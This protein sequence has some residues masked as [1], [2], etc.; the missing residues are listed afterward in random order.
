MT[1]YIDKSALV[2]EIER[3]K[4]CNW[5]ICAG[6]FEF[7]KECYPKYYYSTEIYNEI[8][9]FLDTLDVKE[10]DTNASI[11]QKQ[12][13]DSACERLES[14]LYDKLNSGELEC[15]DIEKLIK[16]GKTALVKNNK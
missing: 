15:G 13:I 14:F 9:S 16:D 2:A 6:N 8:L 11:K 5:E 3:L 4:K 12:L 10:V 1:H 7:L